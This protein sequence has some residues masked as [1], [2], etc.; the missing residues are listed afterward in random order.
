MKRIIL[1]ITLT[2]AL[3]GCQFFSKLQTFADLGTA[4]ISNPVTRDRLQQIEA[5]AVLVFTGLNAWRDACEAGTINVSCREQISAVQVYTRQIPP[6]LTQLR[7]FVRTNDQVNASV[8]FNQV[9][10]LIGVVKGRAAENGVV[11]QEAR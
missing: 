8:V 3:G 10:D 9:V 4:S 6:Y 5:G 2:L 7:R 11:I 1:A